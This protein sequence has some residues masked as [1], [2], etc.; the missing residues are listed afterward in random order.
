M[1]QLERLHEL[2][3]DGRPHSTYEIVEKVYDM[4]TTTIARVGARIYDMKRRFNAI[5]DSWQDKEN[6][7]MW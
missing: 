6:R 4:D 1:S 2:M 5:V 3:S 7:K